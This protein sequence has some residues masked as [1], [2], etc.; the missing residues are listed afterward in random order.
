MILSLAADGVLLVHL[1]F[2]IFVL[3]GGLLVIRWRGI[4]LLHLPA[5]VWGV[6]VELMHL[7]CP[8]TPLEN[9]LRHAAGEAGYEGGFIEHY[10]MPVIYPSGLTEQTQLWL[11]TFVL[12]LNLLLYGLLVVRLKRNNRP[13]SH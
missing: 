4:A 2:I 8:L 9:S 6:T 3:L 5:A 12:V 10:L 1:L 13:R 11:G 7:Q